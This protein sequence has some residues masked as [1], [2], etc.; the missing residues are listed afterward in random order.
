MPADVIGIASDSMGSMFGFRRISRRETRPDDL[1][2]W[3]FDHDYMRLTQQAKSFDAL[4]EWYL[5]NLVTLE[6]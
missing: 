5:S 1:P 4:L 3:F 6:R 2:I